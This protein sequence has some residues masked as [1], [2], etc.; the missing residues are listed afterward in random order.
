MKMSLIP[1]VSL[2]MNKI[3]YTRPTLGKR[4]CGAPL[5]WT[6]KH[7]LLARGN[8]PMKPMFHETSC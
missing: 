7:D 1:G 3:L 6:M 2:R 8:T 4:S 5:K